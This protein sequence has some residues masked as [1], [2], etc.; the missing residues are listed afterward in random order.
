MEVIL[1]KV[2]EV[3]SNYP[4]LKT[5]LLTIVLFL[6]LGVVRKIILNT[7]SKRPG[8]KHEKL[9]L[10]KKVSQYLFYFFILCVFFLWFTQ[11][12][13]FFVSILA[14]AAAIVLALKEL[15]MCFTG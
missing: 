11:L 10:G 12:Q 8:T 9:Q 6:L 13:V 7:I 2:L 5:V 3:F 14:V 4:I 1:P 15:I